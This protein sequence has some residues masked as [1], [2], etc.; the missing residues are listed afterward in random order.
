MTMMTPENM[1][2]RLVILLSACLAPAAA[3]AALA[4]QSDG[5]QRDDRVTGVGS[6][7]SGGAV[8]AFQQCGAAEVAGAPGAVL[9]RPD[10]P[11]DHRETIA[12][13]LEELSKLIGKSGKNDPADARAIALMRGLAGEFSHSGPADQADILRGTSRVFLA[14]RRA[15]K[16]GSRK[17]LLFIEAA[18]SLGAMG[19]DADRLLLAQI[20]SKRHRDDLALQ[21]ELILSLGKTRTKRA[22]TN[23]VKLLKDHRPAFIATSA[24]ALGYFTFEPSKVR[25]TLF[26]AL[27]KALLQAE[28]NA[29]GQNSTALAI[30]KAMRVP[31]NSSMR[32]L[33]GGNASSPADWQRW[34]NKNKRGD[35]D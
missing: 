25:K 26:E 33:S 4:I 35:W 19:E 22:R 18:R 16:D 14:R 29:L 28:G 34:W 21:K 2:M 10:D 11:P 23:L 5:E 30:W 9:E 31:T 1:T 13:R 7:A 20:D 12:T 8:H 24:T 27:L 3:P 6:P 32:T 15:E 17:T